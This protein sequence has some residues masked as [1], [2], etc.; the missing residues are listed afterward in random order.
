[1]FDGGDEFG[2]PKADARGA[3]DGQILYEQP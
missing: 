2:H 1:M 3:G